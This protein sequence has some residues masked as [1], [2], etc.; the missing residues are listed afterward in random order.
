MIIVH[1]SEH[2]IFV[3]QNIYT[4]EKSDV[5]CFNR[6]HTAITLDRQKRKTIVFQIAPL[7]DPFVCSCDIL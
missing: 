7:I 5:F 4:L 1:C 3:R 6:F 2:R